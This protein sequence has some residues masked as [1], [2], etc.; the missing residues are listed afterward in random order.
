MRCPKLIVLSLHEMRG[1]RSSEPYVV[2]SIRS[3]GDRILHLRPDALRL[4]RINLDFWDTT[5]AWE[6]QL[7]M[8]AEVM[9]SSQAERIAAFVTKYADR[10]TIVIHCLAGVSRSAG[11]AAAIS[12]ACDGDDAA[13]LSSRHEPN[14]HVRDLVML[15]MRQHQGVARSWKPELKVDLVDH[16]VMLRM[17]C[18]GKRGFLRSNYF[19]QT[20][21]D[22]DFILS[23]DGLST[24]VIIAAAAAI[25]HFPF[26]Q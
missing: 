1:F 9:T 13:F 15:A 16:P 3:P 22:L 19:G 8:P 2:I 17:L 10:A 18:F 24:I 21:T 7:G 4:A 25:W 6:A 12:A 14:P 5:P 26:A 23:R 20:A 11:V